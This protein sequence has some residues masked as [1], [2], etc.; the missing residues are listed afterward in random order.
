MDYSQAVHQYLQQER[1]LEMVVPFD[2][3]QDKII[4]FDLS[5][6]NPAL[7]EEIYS[8]VDEFSG[9]VNKELANGGARYGIGGY[10]ELR[11][12]YSSSPSF[13]GVGGEEPRR[14][15][16]GTDIWGAAGTPVYAPLDGVVND[17]MFYEQRGDYGGLIILRHVLYDCT[18]F[19]L[20]G[21]LSRASAARA[22]VGSSVGAGV[23]VGELGVPAE[24]G[25]WPPHLHFQVILDMCGREGDF[26]GV[27]K[28]SER[29][30]WMANSPDPDTL[31]GLNEY[32]RVI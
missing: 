6:G 26:P 21:H 8:D 18:F 1:S 17:A 3:E 16:L 7:T 12:I 25:G 9:W 15:H 10:G 23:A 11:K 22:V 4:Q 24:N 27:C 14:L 32:V 13:D 5:G 30:V 20:Y 29:A 19:T 31:L 2:R 28:Y